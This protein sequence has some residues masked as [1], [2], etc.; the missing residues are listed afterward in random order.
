[1]RQ[2]QLMLFQIGVFFP[3]MVLAAFLSPLTC[4]YKSLKINYLILDFCHGWIFD[5]IR[6]CQMSLRQLED[7][8]HKY[9]TYENN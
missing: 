2:I 9:K 4:L 5:S 7:S 6:R 1:L 3:K 8:N